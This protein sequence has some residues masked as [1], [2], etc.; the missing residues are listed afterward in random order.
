MTAVS[1]LVDKIEKSG[2]NID[3]LKDGDARS[4]LIPTK[5]KGLLWCLYSHVCMLISD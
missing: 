1:D 5:Y 4:T 2:Q 3:C